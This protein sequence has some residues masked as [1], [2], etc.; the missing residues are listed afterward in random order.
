MSHNIP[1]LDGSNFYLCDST[2]TI[3]KKKILEL[4]TVS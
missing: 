2:M 3:I 1:P 4:Q